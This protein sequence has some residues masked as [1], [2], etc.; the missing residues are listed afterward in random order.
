MELPDDM[1]EELKKLIEKAKKS[2]FVKMFPGGGILGMNLS[3]LLKDEPDYSG[4]AQVGKLSG[5]CLTEYKTLCRQGEDATQRVNTLM[6][7]AE[8]LKA[9]L[10][11]AAAQ[12]WENI[13]KTCGLPHKR[14]YHITDDFRVLMEPTGKEKK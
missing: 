7:Q 6:L 12:A 13:Y 2:G 1:S 9:E 14:S 11:A 4:W 10:K 5:E 8:K 3:D